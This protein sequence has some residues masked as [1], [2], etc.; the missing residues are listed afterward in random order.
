VK[1]ELEKIEWVRKNLTP[2]NKILIL[3]LKRRIREEKVKIPGALIYDAVI[4]KG[5]KDYRGLMNFC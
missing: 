3:Q 2:E 1:V 4:E 5:V